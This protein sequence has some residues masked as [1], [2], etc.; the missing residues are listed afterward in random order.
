M[1]SGKYSSREQGIERVRGENQPPFCG[2][3]VKKGERR[4]SEGG[5]G[6]NGLLCGFD[7]SR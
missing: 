3:T 4:A 2:G 7:G 5:T 1:R 6:L